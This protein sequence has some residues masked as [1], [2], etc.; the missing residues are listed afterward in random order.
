MKTYDKQIETYVVI[1]PVYF[2]MNLFGH[3]MSPNKICII[4]ILRFNTTKIISCQY[5]VLYILSK[6]K[7]QTG[8]MHVKNPLISVLFLVQKPVLVVHLGVALSR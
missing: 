4:C 3:S 1:L 5:Y 2:Q 7:N 6:K 8:F